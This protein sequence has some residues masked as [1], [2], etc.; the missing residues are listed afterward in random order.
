MENN[1]LCLF[2]CQF[3]TKEVE[4]N[5]DYRFID[6]GY[7]YIRLKKG[8]LNILTEPSS[9]ITLL[10]PDFSMERLYDVVNQGQNAKI[11]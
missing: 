11:Y 2:R 8:G 1:R 7:E 4:Y 6:I 5:I 9:V 10:V 3:V